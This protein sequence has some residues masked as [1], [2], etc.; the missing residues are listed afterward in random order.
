MLRRTF[1]LAPLLFACT[2]KSPEELRLSIREL[3]SSDPK[4]RNRAALKIAAYGHSGVEAIPSLIRVLKTDPS[5]GIRSSAAYA[6][7]S[8]GS[9]EALEAL[10]GYEK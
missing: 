5:K 2:K 8:I 3:S 10:D 6:L 1:I 9:K 4:V 7:R